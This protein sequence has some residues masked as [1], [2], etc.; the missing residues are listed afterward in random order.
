MEALSLDPGVETT[1]RHGDF[2]RAFQ[3][4]LSFEVF[5][6][7]LILRYDQDLGHGLIFEVA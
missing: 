2:E 4:Q 1:G 7:D 3:G 6:Q 5:D